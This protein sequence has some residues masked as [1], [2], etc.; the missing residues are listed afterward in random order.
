MMSLHHVMKWIFIIC[1]ASLILNFIL[2]GITGHPEK[3]INILG[4][5]VI[6][7]ISGVSMSMA[8]RK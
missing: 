1:L 7:A 5:I 6:G 2:Y 4:S 8:R 3:L